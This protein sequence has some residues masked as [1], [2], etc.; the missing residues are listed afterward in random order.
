MQEE[1]M[2]VSPIDIAKQ[3]PAIIG[4]GA[5]AGGLNAVKEFFSI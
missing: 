3:K 5:S 2:E 1:L 4:I